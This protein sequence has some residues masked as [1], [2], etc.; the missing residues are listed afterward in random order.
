MQANLYLAYTK[1]DEIVNHVRL[2]SSRILGLDQEVLDY[3]VEN[4]FADSSLGKGLLIIPRKIVQVDDD[5]VEHCLSSTKLTAV[6]CEPLDTSAARRL[7]KVRK[8]LSIVLTTRS[9]RYVDE[10]QINFMAQSHVRKYIEVHLH[11]FVVH[12]LE[13]GR[14]IDVEKEFFILSETIELALKRDT[15]IVVSSASPTLKETLL[16]THIDLILFSLG[17]TKRER[18][19]ILEFYPRE[20]VFNWLN[21]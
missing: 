4:L 13:N 15:G 2:D 20:F 9:V 6:G 17:F 16:T 3:C 21:H 11:P 1:C 12:M 14:G 5:N 10:A 18:R 19:L 7:A 8:F